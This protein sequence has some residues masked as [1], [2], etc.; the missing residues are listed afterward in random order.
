MKQTDIDHSPYNEK[1]KSPTE[2]NI[3]KGSYQTKNR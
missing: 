1:K 2:L 3:V